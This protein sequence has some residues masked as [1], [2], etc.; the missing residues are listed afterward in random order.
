MVCLMFCW[1]FWISELCLVE[2]WVGLLFCCLILY[3]TGCCEL[4]LL[5]RLDWF[6]LYFSGCGDYWFV[7]ITFAGLFWFS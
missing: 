7:V 4:V 3:L 6:T 2:V 1:I 5:V